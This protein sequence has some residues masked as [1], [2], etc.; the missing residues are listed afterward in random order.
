MWNRMK[1]R[2]RQSREEMKD[3]V[4][5]AKRDDT[6]FKRKELISPDPQISKIDNMSIASVFTLAEAKMNK[7]AESW[8]EQVLQAAAR[9]EPATHS[10]RAKWYESFRGLRRPQQSSGGRRPSSPAGGT[11][12]LQ[13]L[14]TRDAQAK[15]LFDGATEK[16]K[17]LAAEGRLSKVPAE[18]QVGS[19][20][21]RIS[22]GEDAI[23]AHQQLM[24]LWAKAGTHPEDRFRPEN[25]QVGFIMPTA[26]EAVADIL[27]ARERERVEELLR[28]HRP[29]GGELGSAEYKPTQPVGPRLGALRLPGRDGDGVDAELALLAASRPPSPPPGSFCEKRYHER[30]TT[31]TAPTA[32]VGGLSAIMS[33]RPL[34]YTRPLHARTTRGTLYTATSLFC[35]SSEP[36]C[37]MPSPLAV[38]KAPSDAERKAVRRIFGAFK[39]RQAYLGKGCAHS[40]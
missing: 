13:A 20:H 27:A 12:L 24:S 34:C 23:V 40:P 30:G 28:K 19:R 18:R 5:E 14:Q 39:K 38:P 15:A 4:R 9:P 32:L 2:L 17:A 6:F 36:H 29:S 31:A 35:L 33:N 1:R 37:G 16:Q 10:Q 25:N 21:R 22:M 11:S 26:S 7:S 8:R 3:V